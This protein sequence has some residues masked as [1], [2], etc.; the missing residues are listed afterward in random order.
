MN[1]IYEFFELLRNYLKTANI[2]VSTNLL[3]TAMFV[4]LMISFTFSFFIYS[5]L[6]LSKNTAVVVTT[7]SVVASLICFISF[8][9]M[10]ISERS[11]LLFS[12]LGIIFLCVIS[13]KLIDCL[14]RLVCYIR[15]RK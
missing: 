7:K 8:M 15:K 3:T 14:I 10:L 11:E 12:V 5:K 4:I 2:E 1:E 9:Y 13:G 6:S